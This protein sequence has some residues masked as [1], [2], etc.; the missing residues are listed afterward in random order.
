MK[1]I[2]K[3]YYFPGQ[4]VIIL[5]II[6]LLTL[7]SC[8]KR[9]LTYFQDI[10][11]EFDYSITNDQFVAPEIVVG[12]LLEITVSTI[13]PESNMLFNYG[14]VTDI[15]GG[16][17]PVSNNARIDGYLVDPNGEVDFPILGKVKVSGLNKEQV[18]KLL[19]DQLSSLVVDPKVEVR[20]LNF[21]ITVIG[22][23]TNPASF[24]VPNERITV[25]EALGLAGDMTVYGLRDNVMLLRESSQGKIVHRFDMGNKDLLSSPYFYL[26][27]NDVIYVEADKKKL[28]QANVNPNTIAVVSILSSIAVA[29]IFSWST[30]FN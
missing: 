14:I 28:V 15:A 4:R 17:G 7:S 12:D 6:S 2:N 29:L 13:N 18:K 19:K 9:N 23:V 26:R 20:F 16:P 10:D 30:I 11:T 5:M 21:R 1:I 8:A 24:I 22:E 3:A 25:L 27:Q